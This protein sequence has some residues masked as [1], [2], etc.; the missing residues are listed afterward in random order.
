[1][2]GA[3]GKPKSA[4]APQEKVRREPIAIPATG[5]IPLSND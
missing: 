2:A 4:A 1:M 3:D 5:L